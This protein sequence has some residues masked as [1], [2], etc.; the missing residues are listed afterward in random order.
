[1]IRHHQLKNYISTQY[2]NLI[3]Y[4][5]A[6]DIYALNVVSRK[7]T[8]VKSLPWKP[9]C[10]DAAYGWICVGG[11]KN[12]QCAFLSI[13]GSGTPGTQLPSHAEVDDLLPLDL[14]PEYRNVRHDDHH[15]VPPPRHQHEQSYKL[16]Y[17]DI[18]TDRVNS[19]KIH[20]LPTSN[21]DINSEIVVVVT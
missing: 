11:N 20:M 13:H 17:H 8:L 16:H 4:A 10:L 15:S 7:R 21:S 12:G 18:G 5:S 6:F 14:D 3:Y 9:Y 1:M 19:V 2:S